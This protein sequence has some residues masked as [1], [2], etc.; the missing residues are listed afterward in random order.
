MEFYYNWLS[1][2]TGEDWRTDAGVICIILAHT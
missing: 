1:G 2:F